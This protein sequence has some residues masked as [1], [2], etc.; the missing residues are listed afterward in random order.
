MIHEQIHC[1]C[2]C[3]KYAV[4]AEMASATIE[5]ITQ[6][7]AMNRKTLEVVERG[8]TVARTTALLSSS[9][10]L[11]CPLS[12]R[13]LSNPPAH[14]QTPGTRWVIVAVLLPALVIPFLQLVLA[15][16]EA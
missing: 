15:E 13:S 7:S 6:L 1:Q 3:T 10:S 2:L 4:D 11:L 8:L 14:H 9:A 16:A 5:K 12:Q